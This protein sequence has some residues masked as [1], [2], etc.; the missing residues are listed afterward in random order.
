MNKTELLIHLLLT[1]YVH[2]QPIPPLLFSVMVNGTIIYPPTYLSQT[3][4]V[5]LGIRLSITPP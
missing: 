1:P 2:I 3:P 4:E 5:I